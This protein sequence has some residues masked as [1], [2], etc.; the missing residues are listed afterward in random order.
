MG[1]IGL[2][3]AHRPRDGIVLPVL[4][5]VRGLLPGRWETP[6]LSRPIPVK[7]G[8]RFRCPRNIAQT[9]ESGRPSQPLPMAGTGSEQSM[10]MV[11][12]FSQGL[13]THLLTEPWH[14]GQIQQ[15]IIGR[16]LLLLPM[17]LV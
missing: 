14:G 7:H 9:M 17:E 6:S 1:K 12:R 4:Q 16:L 2:S 8:F 3:A 5:M 11:A 10:D 13:F 15:M